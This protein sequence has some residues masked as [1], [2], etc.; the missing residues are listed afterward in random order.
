MQPEGC[1]QLPFPSLAAM[2][3]P[4]GPKGVSSSSLRSC[5]DLETIASSTPSLGD[6]NEA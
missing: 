4:E 2:A 5:N 3:A 1:T 6:V